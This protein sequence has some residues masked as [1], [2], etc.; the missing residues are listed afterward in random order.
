DHIRLTGCHEWSLQLEHYL[1]TLKKKPGA[2]AGSTALQQAD[3]KIKTIYDTYYNNRAKE[4]VELLQYIK[5]ESTLSEIERS[6]KELCRIHPSHVT[7]DK[8]KILCAKNK[9]TAVS[10]VPKSKETN[11][12]TEHAKANLKMYD[13]LFQTESVG[14]EEAIA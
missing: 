4:F 12:I 5:E 11:D 1:E 6:I 3:K 8:I 2:L 14:K 7:T 9:N 13:E 10:S